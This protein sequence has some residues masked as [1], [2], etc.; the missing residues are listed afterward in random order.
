[1]YYWMDQSTDEI[2]E[3]LGIPTG[4][5]KSYLARARQRLKERAKSLGIEGLE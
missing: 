5:V 3:A 4:T 2:G 1:M